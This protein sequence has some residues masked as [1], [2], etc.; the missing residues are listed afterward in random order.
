MNW[1]AVDSIVFFVF[2]Y[3]FLIYVDE[4]LKECFKDRLVLFNVIVFYFSKVKVQHFDQSQFYIQKLIVASTILHVHHHAGS[5][6]LAVA[7][8]ESA[9]SFDDLLYDRRVC[10]AVLHAIFPCYVFQI[11]DHS[12]KPTIFI[13]LSSSI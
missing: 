6:G 2:I 7:E 3:Q 1:Y 10:N 4:V 13:V 5:R 11:M 9:E 12:P 8:I